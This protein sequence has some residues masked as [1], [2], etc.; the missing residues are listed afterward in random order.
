[1]RR[2]PRCCWSA[3]R[4]PPSA[5]SSGRSVRI[6][7]LDT[8]TQATNPI[9]RWEW[10]FVREDTRGELW[11]A[12][13]QHLQLTL[14]AVGIGL[15]IA[16]GL[17][18]V[19]LRFRWTFAPI[20]AF[21]SFLYTIPSVALFGLLVTRFGNT[22]SAEIAL[23]E[24]HA[25][26]ARAEHRRRDRRR[27]AP[28]SPT[29]PTASGCRATRRLLTVEL[30]LALPVIVAGIRVATVT[31]VGLV[32]ITAIIQLGGLGRLIFDGYG[33]QYYTKIVVG[34]ALS[35]LLALVLDVAFNRIEVAAHPV[36][37]AAGGVVSL[38]LLARPAPTSRRTSSSGSPTA[39]PAPTRAASRSS[40]GSTV[41]HSAVALVVVVA[42]RRPASPP[43]SPTTAVASWPPPSSVSIGRAVP[44][45]TVVGVA[46][47]VSLRNGFGLE[48]W[49]IIVALVLLGLPPVFANTY[50]AVRGVDPEPGGAR[51][52]AMGSTHRQVLLRV[53][54]PLA[55]PV[56]LAGVRTAAVQIVATEPL[57][58]FFGGE[59][60]G[61]YLAPG[62]EHAATRS[63]CRPARSS[64]PASPSPPSSPSSGWPRSSCPTASA[65]ASPSRR[66]P[67][68]AARRDAPAT[69]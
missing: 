56:I 15:V 59:G 61:A 30:P 34:S 67:P 25:A 21:T 40:C 2:P 55:L 58:A 39:P 66:S 10:L 45:V 68:A 26:R 37:A 23:V 64:S 16:A 44:T 31:T 57:G 12:T 65:A 3:A 35:V 24:L 17:A 11:D 41:W 36:G 50:A 69:V 54:L 28:R 49:P 32:G 43:C 6:A 29:L 48:P 46:V 18:A 27:A 13:L 60:L 38:L 52:A 33:T 22:M 1:M 7:G 4:W 9:I 42:D 19:A 5:R 14:M 47:I 63:R 62:P 20:T 53:E 8:E 51:R